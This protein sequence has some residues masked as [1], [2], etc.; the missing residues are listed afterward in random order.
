MGGGWSTPRPGRF[1]LGKDPT[2]IHT[3]IMHRP[4]RNS[5]TCVSAGKKEVAFDCFNIYINSALVRKYRNYKMFWTEFWSRFEAGT[6]W[7]KLKKSCKQYVITS[8]LYFMCLHS[9]PLTNTNT[10]CR[11]LLSAKHYW[12][13]QAESTVFLDVTQCGLL[14]KR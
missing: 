3:L 4:I 7:V 2:P 13:I 8:L 5:R 10:S 1:T 12:L 9:I 6:L 14:R 11:F